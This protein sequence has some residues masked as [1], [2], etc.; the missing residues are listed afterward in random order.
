MS[1]IY[2][3]NF[4]P[5][6][7]YEKAEELGELVHMTKGYIP[8]HKLAQFSKFFQNYAKQANKD[9]YLLLSGSNLVC[10]IAVA[11]WLEVHGEV[12]VLQHTKS[13]D[14]GEISDSYLVYHVTT[15]NHE[16]QAS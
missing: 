7:S 2:N 5:R 16:R 1:K 8:P 10:V 6:H 13:K 15:N 3:T 4:N 12:Q 14:D 9:D 11:S